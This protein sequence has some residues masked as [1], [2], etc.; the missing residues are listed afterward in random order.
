MRTGEGRKDARAENARVD[1]ATCGRDTRVSTD[2]VGYYRLEGEK[3]IVTLGVGGAAYMVVSPQRTVP[4]TVEFL[5]IAAPPAND[6]LLRMRDGQ[7]API[8]LASHRACS[9]G[10]DWPGRLPFLRLSTEIISLSV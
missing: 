2:Q 7:D 10:W 3:L 5:D 8:S 4:A 1:S 6:A 9:A